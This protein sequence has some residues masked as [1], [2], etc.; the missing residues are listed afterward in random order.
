[1]LGVQ[2]STVE[3]SPCG[4]SSVDT[5][6]HTPPCRTFSMGCLLADSPPDDNFID[7]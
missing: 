7:K 3:M 4:E 5:L 1:L 2:P 6:D